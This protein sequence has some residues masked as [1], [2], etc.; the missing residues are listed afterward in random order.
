MILQNHNRSGLEKGTRIALA[1]SATMDSFIKMYER[2]STSTSFPCLRR[3]AQTP[4]ARP[5]V[6]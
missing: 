5:L 2:P 3:P 1:A 6:A 4:M